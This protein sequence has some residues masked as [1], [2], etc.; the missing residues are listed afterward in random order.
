M[1]LPR[2]Q[3]GKPLHHDNGKPQVAE[4][5]CCGVP[6]EEVVNSAN[7]TQPAM[8]ISLSCN[9]HDGSGISEVSIPFFSAYGDVSNP[10]ADGW[11]WA[12]DGICPVKN[13]AGLGNTTGDITISFWCNG[14]CPGTRPEGGWCFK[15]NGHLPEALPSGNCAFFEA[16]DEA[17]GPLVDVRDNGDIYT[18]SPIV[19]DIILNGSGGSETPCTLTIE[20]P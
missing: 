5:C 14:S 9:C 10:E 7:S 13:C 17:F 1:G 3:A 4:E 19:V 18:T 15:I 12:G 16:V 11:T 2:H 20:I 8:L 6:C